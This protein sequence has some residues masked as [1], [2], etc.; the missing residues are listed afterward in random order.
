LSGRISIAERAG[1]ETKLAND[2]TFEA[3]VTE[4]TGKPAHVH[5]QSQTRD[6]GKTKVALANERERSLKVQ[7]LVAGKTR[8]GLSYDKAFTAVQRENPELFAAM[9]KPQEA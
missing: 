1:Y 4:I 9:T 8:D 2:A 3:T 5:T 6:L 7:E